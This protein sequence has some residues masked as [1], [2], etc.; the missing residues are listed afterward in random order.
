MKKITVPERAGS[1]TGARLSVTIDVLVTIFVRRNLK[2]VE[3]VYIFRMNVAKG[4]S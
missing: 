3:K 4:V 1:Q 2:K